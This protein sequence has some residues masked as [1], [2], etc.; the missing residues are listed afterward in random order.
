MKKAPPDEVIQAAFAREVRKCTD[1][2]MAMTRYVDHLH[3]AEAEHIHDWRLEAA[4][5]IVERQRYKK[6]RNET[7]GNRAESPAAPAEKGK[8]KRKRERQ[9]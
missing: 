9:S 4:E 6:V 7:R 2:A 8:G 1:M 3:A 5:K